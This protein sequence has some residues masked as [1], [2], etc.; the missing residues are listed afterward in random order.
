MRGEYILPAALF[1]LTP[2]LYAGSSVEHQLQSAREMIDAHAVTNHFEPPTRSSETKWQVAKV[3]G[4]A[5]ELK[6]TAHRE[7]PNTVFTAD[8]VLGLSEDKV[9]TWDFDLR[10]LRPEFIMSDT[11]S[12]PHIKIF[13]SGDIFH[14]KTEFVWRNVNQDGTVADTRSWSTTGNARNLWMYFDSPDA[15][16]TLLVRKLETDLRGAVSACTSHP[17]AHSGTRHHRW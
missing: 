15:D 14:L 1:V 13:A 12:G 7:E 11:I 5:V 16:N 3:D 17:S 6:E 10:N 2:V 9:I 8:R 4:C